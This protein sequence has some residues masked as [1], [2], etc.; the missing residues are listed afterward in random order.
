MALKSLLERSWA[1][2]KLQSKLIIAFLLVVISGSIV[3][4]S[5]V[6]FSTMYFFKEYVDNFTQSKLDQW[7]AYFD[8]YYEKNGGSWA[9]V[10]ELFSETALF[11]PGFFFAE[12]KA[13]IRRIVLKDLNGKVL[14]DS[15]NIVSVEKPSTG[16]AGKILE[17]SVHYKGEVVGQLILTTNS[18]FEGISGFEQK[19]YKS[20]TNAAI[21]ANVVS[22][23]FAIGLAIFFSRR[24]S[25][26]LV[27]LAQATDKLA[28]KNFKY[29]LFMPWE[30]EIGYLAK[31]FNSM[32]DVIEKKEE[33]KSRL[34]AD[35]AHELRTPVTVLRGHLESLQAG[36]IEPSEE[37]IVSLHDEVL[38]LSRLINDLQEMS[39]VDS[40]KSELNLELLECSEILQAIVNKFK[41]V[42]SGKTIDIELEFPGEK[43]FINA[44]RD[45]LMQVLS[46]IMSNAVRHS[47]EGGKI[48]VSFE[49]SGEDGVSFSISDSGPGISP[50]D[51]PYIF[52]RFYRESKSRNRSDGGSGLGLAIAKS[53]VVAHGG[54]ISVECP[55]SGGSKFTVVLPLDQP[56]KN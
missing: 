54:E 11:P 43:C 32:A 48:V 39:L 17:G 21:V 8:R 40:G 16:A 7:I 49:K 29:R 14:A 6:G 19:F 56:S 25:I 18:P 31:A 55:K 22:A 10:D 23:L 52:E 37:V 42:A 28:E 53:L 35:V 9:G 46:N 51:Q 45:R 41:G 47:P 36:V 1:N 2:L 30:D 20:V 44:D 33:T 13:S 27:S 12:G 38:R 34:I 3:A 50:E 5:I 15:N 26:P 4:S 24:I